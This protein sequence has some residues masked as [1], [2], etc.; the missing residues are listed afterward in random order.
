MRLYFDDELSRLI[1]CTDFEWGERRFVTRFLRSGDVFIDIGANIGLYTVIAARRVGRTGCVYAFEPSPRA[2]QRLLANVQLNRCCNVSCFQVALSETGGN[3]TLTTSLD[4]YEAWNSL[5]HPIAGGAFNTQAVTC[6]SWDEFARASGLIG[7]VTMMKID[8]EGWESRML[9]GARETFARQDAPLLQVEF[10]DEAAH[11]AGSSC[12]E[13]YQILQ[14][15]GYQMFVYDGLRKCLVPD[16][17]RD[18]YPYANII[19]TKSLATVLA[20]LG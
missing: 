10:T 13:L 4:G 7:R 1:Y 14:T 15:Y 19:A 6:L 2:F 16:P 12:R 20:R 9:Q 17:L 3:A 18:S 11:A 5:G 8:I